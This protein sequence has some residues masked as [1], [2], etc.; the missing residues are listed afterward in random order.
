MIYEGD[1]HVFCHIDNEQT[2][3]Y[4]VKYNIKKYKHGDIENEE[5]NYT[6]N[7][8]FTHKSEC[9]FYDYKLVNNVIKLYYKH[10]NEIKIIDIILLEL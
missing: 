3:L 7:I 8:H 2:D 10:K 4:S 6:I 5:T 9:V 1:I